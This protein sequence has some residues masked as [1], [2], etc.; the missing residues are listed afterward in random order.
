VRGGKGDVFLDCMSANRLLDKIKEAVYKESSGGEADA[1]AWVYDK[2][3]FCCLHEQSFSFRTFL[4][5][6]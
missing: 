6:Q 3:Y 5:L 4:V 1:E 2:I